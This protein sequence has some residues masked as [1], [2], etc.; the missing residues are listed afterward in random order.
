MELPSTAT[1]RAPVVVV[2]AA[3]AAVVVV[4]AVAAVSTE[5]ISIRIEGVMRV[6]V[7]RGATRR[8][9]RKLTMTMMMTIAVKTTNMFIQGISNI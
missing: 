8:A 1:G 5:A 7:N 6:L 3:A 2:V 4:A 9:Q